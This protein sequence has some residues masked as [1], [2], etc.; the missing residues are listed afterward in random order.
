ML[1]ILVHLKKGITQKHHP[2][3]PSLPMNRVL[4]WWVELFFLMVDILAIPE[5]YETVLAFGK[6]QTRP[7]T[8]HEKKLAYSVFGD[9]IAY[10]RVRVDESATVICRSNHIFYVSFFTINSWGKF[11]PEIFIH[12]M[13]HVWQFQHFGSVYIPRALLAQRREPG[14]NYG[15]IKPLLNAVAHDHGFLPFN[16]EQQADIVADYFCLREGLVPNWCAP[17]ESNLLPVFEYFIK[18]LWW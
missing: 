18:K 5:I 15:G 11:N 10:E 4:L 17:T 7:L 8:A 14:Y 16:F 3:T 9:S 2:V 6:W 13:M 1:R 12:E